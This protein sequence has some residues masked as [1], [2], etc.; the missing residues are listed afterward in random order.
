MDDAAADRAQ[1]I[2]IDAWYRLA[3]KPRRFSGAEG[4]SPAAE[5][6]IRY[7]ALGADR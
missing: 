5:R 6:L 2:P 4:S 3:L 7:A 1:R